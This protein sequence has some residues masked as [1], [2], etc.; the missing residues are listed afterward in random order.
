MELINCLLVLSALSRA[1]TSLIVVTSDGQRLICVGNFHRPQASYTASCQ[2]SKTCFKVHILALNYR[3]NQDASYAIWPLSVAIYLFEFHLRSIFDAV[4][5]MLVD[6]YY[7]GIFQTQS[8][9]FRIAEI[10]INLSSTRLMVISIAQTR[11]LFQ[12]LRLF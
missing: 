12:E 5:T 11:T 8:S 10:A 2:G 9:T 1:A 6:R 3:N 7:L 4:F